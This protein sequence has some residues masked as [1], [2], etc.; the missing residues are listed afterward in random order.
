MPPHGDPWVVVH[1]IIIRELLAEADSRF[2]LRVFGNRTLFDGVT[3]CMQDLFTCR[4]L[5]PSQASSHHAH[6]AKKRKPST[7]Y[8]ASWNV[9]S[10]K[11]T[12]GP[13]E[14]ASSRGDRGEDRKVVL[15]VRGIRR[16]TM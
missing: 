13:V 3:H 5:A 10:M 15:I 11:D 1:W 7:W 16:Y 12:E 8:L 6:R 14:I 4:R 2:G 9:D